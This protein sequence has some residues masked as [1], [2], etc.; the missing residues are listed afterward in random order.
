[1]TDTD[2][3]IRGTTAVVTGSSR[4]IG[5]SISKRFAEQGVDVVVCSRDIDAVTTTADTINSSESTSGSALAVECDVTDWPSVQNLADQAKSAFGAVDILVNNAGVSFQAPFEELSQNAWGTIIDTNLNGVF[6][7]TRIIGDGMIRN[8]GGGT[9]INISSVAGRDGAPEMSHYAASKAALD[10]L[11]RTLAYE[12]SQ[13]GIRVNGVAPGLIA[14]EG[15]KQQMNIDGDDIDLEETD[16]QI[17]T[18]EEIAMVVQFLASNAARYIQGQTI[19]V[20]GVPRMAHTRHH[21]ATA[22]VRGG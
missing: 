17:G 9:I 4:G 5:E 7:C 15:L 11:T 12:W 18:P 22:Y 10:T 3:E 19:D 20:E 2:F 21:D 8:D 6:N 16:R 14:T 13:Y 1:M